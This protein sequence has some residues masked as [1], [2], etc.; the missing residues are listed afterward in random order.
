MRRLYDTVTNIALMGVSTMSAA[1]A[2]GVKPSGVFGY[3]S[4]CICLRKA[5]V[6]CSHEPYGAYD[7]CWVYIFSNKCVTKNT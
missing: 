3:L 6:C 1:M 2:T 7:F 4:I 5:V